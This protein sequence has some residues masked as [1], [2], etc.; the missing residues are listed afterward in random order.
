MNKR[1]LAVTELLTPRKWQLVCWCQYDVTSCPG[2]TWRVWRRTSNNQTINQSWGLKFGLFKITEGPEHPSIQFW[3]SLPF[4]RLMHFVVAIIW[5]H[6]VHPV[7]NACMYAKGILFKVQIS[8]CPHH[9]FNFPSTKHLLWFDGER[10]WWNK[11]TPPVTC[12][13]CGLRWKDWCNYHAGCPV[14]LDSSTWCTSKWR[15]QSDRRNF[16]SVHY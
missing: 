9:N 8:F 2:R 7:D 3:F 12:T 13:V 6:Y 1:F 10:P 16:I 11:I 15:G 5:W 14:K 4:D